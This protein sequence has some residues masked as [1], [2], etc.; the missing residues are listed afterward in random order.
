MIPGKSWLGRGWRAERAPRFQKSWRNASTSRRRSGRRRTRYVP[1]VV[2]GRR[3]GCV[4][5]SV[6][7]A[8]SNGG[9]GR[10]PEVKMFPGSRF[11]SQS[12]P[13]LGAMD[14][15]SSQCSGTMGTRLKRH[16]F[17]LPAAWNGR[18]TLGTVR[19]FCAARSRPTQVRAAGKYQSLQHPR[20]PQQR[21]ARTGSPSGPKPVWVATHQ[22][23][24]L[25]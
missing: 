5:G 19:C 24:E 12:V 17:T 25:S 6:T 10:L 21:S 13:S 4:T 11:C 23:A 3:V 16:E 7:A 20:S 1:R 2:C 22:Y 8:G 14:S 9:I 15:S 18:G